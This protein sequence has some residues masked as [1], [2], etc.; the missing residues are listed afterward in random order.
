MLNTN[1]VEICLFQAPSTELCATLLRAADEPQ[2]AAV[3][4]RDA[5]AQ[6]LDIMQHVGTEK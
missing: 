3:Q 2:V 1:T 5:I 4:N 6:R